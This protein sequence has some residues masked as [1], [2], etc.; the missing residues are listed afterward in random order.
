MVKR[1]CMRCHKLTG[2][3][4]QFEGPF[5]AVMPIC[6]ACFRSHKDIL[7]AQYRRFRVAVDN[8]VTVK[9]ANQIMAKRLR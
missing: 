5:S 4:V 3:T 8:G 1:P 9:R 6:N 7:V 2:N